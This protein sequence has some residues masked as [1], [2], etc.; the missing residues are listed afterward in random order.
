[1]HCLTMNSVYSLKNRRWLGKTFSLLLGSVYGDGWKF[2]V[3]EKR[4]TILKLQRKTESLLDNQS[5]RLQGKN[6]FPSFF[7][8]IASTL[9]SKRGLCYLFL[10]IERH[11][12]SVGFFFWLAEFLS[13]VIV[14]WILNVIHRRQ[15]FSSS[16]NDFHFSPPAFPL[17]ME[18]VICACLN[19]NFLVN[20]SIRTH[21][22]LTDF[23]FCDFRLSSL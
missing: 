5:K 7:L 20:S 22:A 19:L 17:T 6:L 21:I 23:V 4:K 9:H 3:E 1:M 8:G 2:C 12:K 11:L 16:V 10:V 13:S 15:I 14:P 18:E